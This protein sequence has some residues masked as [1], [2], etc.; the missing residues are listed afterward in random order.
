M[1]VVWLALARTSTSQRA[2]PLV[3]LGHEEGGQSSHQ[4]GHRRD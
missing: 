4:T 1:L 2:L 3:V